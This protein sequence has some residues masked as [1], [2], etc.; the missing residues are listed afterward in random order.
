MNPARS[1]AVSF[2]LA[3]AALPAATPSQTARPN[4]VFILADDLG[5][6]DVNAFAARLSARNAP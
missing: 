1:I 2:A 4:I 6:V 3:A 5:Y